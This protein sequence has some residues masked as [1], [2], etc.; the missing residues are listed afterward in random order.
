MGL[1]ESVGRRSGR[2]A[3]LVTGN[4]AVTRSVRHLCLQD[5]DTNTP[6]ETNPKRL[7]LAASQ[8]QRRNTAA[9]G[10]AGYVSTVP[11]RPNPMIGK[12]SGPCHPEYRH[13]HSRRSPRTAPADGLLDELDARP[14]PSSATEPHERVQFARVLYFNPR[15]V[16]RQL[17]TELTV[18]VPRRAPRTP[19][20][21]VTSLGWRCAGRRQVP[22]PVMSA[23]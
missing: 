11:R 14:R 3:P 4:S 16:P 9:S 18:S 1:K 23:P 13:R 12:S 20:S 17:D 21:T 5:V 7:G 15:H 2:G 22:G 19:S 6:P 8:G 10:S